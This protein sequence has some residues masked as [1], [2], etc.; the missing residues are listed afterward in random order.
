[1]GQFFAKL[2][3]EYLMKYFKKAQPYKIRILVFFVEIASKLEKVIL[4]F[5]RFNPFPS[6]PSVA[7]NERKQNKL[8]SIVLSNKPGPLFLEF[9]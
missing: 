7:T 9:S 4:T 6:L 3:G 2:S 5:S 8:H 1:M